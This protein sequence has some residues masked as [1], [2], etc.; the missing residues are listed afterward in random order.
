M[1]AALFVHR[2]ERGSNAAAGPDRRL[3]MTGLG[4][5]AIVLLRDNCE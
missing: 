1:R 5:S 4:V 3:S 2:F